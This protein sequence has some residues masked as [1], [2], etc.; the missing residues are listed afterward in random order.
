MPP[1]WDLES[2]TCSDGSEPDA[3]SL[4]A[5]ETVTCTFTNVARADLHIVKVAERDGVD[6]SFTTTG[7]L[8]PATFT[9]QNGGQQDFTGLVPGTYGTAETV[10]EGW[11]LESATCDNS[12][13]PAAVTLGPG[14]DVTCTYT[15]V[16]ERGALSIHK[17]AKHAA[18]PGGT[19]NHAGVT[20]TVTNATNGTSAVV[21]TDA[22][23]NACVADLP[24][25][26]LDGDY[27]IT[28]TVPAG[29]VNAEP[30][31]TYTVVED[32]DCASAMVASFVNTP[33]TNLSVVVDSQID[34]GTAST[35]ACVPGGS[36][37]TGPNGD[38]S[39][40]LT[41]LEPGTYVCTVVVDP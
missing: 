25:S 6:F 27:T 18:A 26:F 40:D 16:V 41:N 10:P 15:N 24:V 31:Q 7:G 2:A 37:A 23:G 3:I 32:T 30:V 17:S 28:E 29:Y 13:A 39:L 21:Q 5:A 9:L 36:A 38:G 14:D 34:G 22:D 33:L 8:D 4:Q 35:I 20:F 12:D 19:R 1:G 11:D